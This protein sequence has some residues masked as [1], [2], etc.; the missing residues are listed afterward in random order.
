MDQDSKRTPIYIP[1]HAHETPPSRFE[2]RKRGFIW[3]RVGSFGI[4][5]VTDLVMSR[6]LYF[7]IDWLSVDLTGVQQCKV[8]DKSGN[9]LYP[10]SGVICYLVALESAMK[11][12][13]DRLPFW[14]IPDALAASGC[15]DFSHYDPITLQIRIL[16]KLWR[17]RGEQRHLEC[18]R[19]ELSKY[20]LDVE[21]FTF[22]V[23]AT[24]NRIYRFDLT[25]HPRPLN[26]SQ[27]EFGVSVSTIL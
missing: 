27:W 25:I 6:C 16:E 26:E 11:L 17:K 10:Q 8:C 9:E 18:A 23:E 21:K 15:S 4:N 3:P 14:K 1:T 7:G 13:D 2:W 19:R 12:T 22:D 20:L 24:Q 5:L